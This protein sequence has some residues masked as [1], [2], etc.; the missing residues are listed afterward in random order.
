[1]WTVRFRR[2]LETAG[3]AMMSD[4]R[5]RGLRAYGAPHACYRHIPQQNHVDSQCTRRAEMIRPM[6]RVSLTSIQFSHE[7]SE[8]DVREVLTR[9]LTISDAFKIEYEPPDETWGRL[10]ASDTCLA[11]VCS[12]LP[13]AFVLSGYVDIVNQ[14]A[15]TP[16]LRVINV[17]SFDEPWLSADRGEVEAIFGRGL[18]TNVDWKSMS[19]NDFWWATV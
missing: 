4:G 14:L 13:L 11:I 9:L 17:E 2:V 15:G 3:A 10:L 8:K 6:T 18:S 16:R 1:M 19:V 5:D 7:W 12:R